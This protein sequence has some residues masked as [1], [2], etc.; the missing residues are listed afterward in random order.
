MKGDPEARQEGP[1]LPAEPGLGRYLPPYDELRMVPLSPTAT[2]V[3]LPK[4][5]PKSAS[6][7]PELRAVQVVPYSLVNE[8]YS[9]T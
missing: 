3:P 4:V 5:T 1:G 6:V 7:V 9:A 8:L 2:K